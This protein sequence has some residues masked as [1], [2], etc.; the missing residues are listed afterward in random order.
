MSDFAP[1]DGLPPNHVHPLSR[2][3]W[4]AWLSENH[5]REDGVWL[6]RYKKATGQPTLTNAEVTKEALCFGWVDSRPRKVDAGRSRLYV[7]PRKPGSNW[8][9][10]NKRYVAELEANGRMTE[11]GRVKIEA[12]KRDGSWNALDDVENLVV[13][14]DLAAAFASHPGSA[15]H[16]EA[17]PRSTKRGILEWILNAKR[18]PTRAKRIEETARLAAQNKRANQWPREG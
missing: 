5:D 6:V 1:V 13:P 14:E 3:A 4:R 17:F 9:A 16:W 11:A 18:T 12:A 10:L 8:S 15:E 2:E 7:A